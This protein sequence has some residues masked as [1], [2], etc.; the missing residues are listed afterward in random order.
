MPDTR[1]AANGCALL[2]ETQVREAHARAAG[3]EACASIA[4]SMGVSARAISDAI[5][6][7]TW[8]HLALP[9]L[10]ANRV[11]ILAPARERTARTNDAV[12][13]EDDRVCR[14]LVAANPDGM[15]LAEIG[16]ALGV[17]RERARQVEAIALQKVGAICALSGITRED[18]V[19][20]LMSKRTS[21]F[22]SAN[23]RAESDEMPARGRTGGLGGWHE[24]TDGP[25]VELEALLAA[26]EERAEFVDDVTRI[27]RRHA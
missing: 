19:A 24:I 10:P 1:G 21:A 22:A 13:F 7:S 5:N 14:D 17:T 15:N 6:G 2:T 4:E 20:A 9:K 27:A 18:F 8:A 16:E 25:L 12:R 23:D 26:V 11:V 3:G